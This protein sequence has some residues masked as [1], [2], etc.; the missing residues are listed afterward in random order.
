VFTNAQ[1][2][3]RDNSVRK[4]E[5]VARKI[6][7]SR[8]S[9][10]SRQAI[11]R[12]AHACLAQA[13]TLITR[14]LPSATGKIAWRWQALPAPRPLYNLD[15]LASNPTAFVIL[16]EG[17]KA[18]DAAAVL[19]PECVAT[20]TLNGAHSPH[21]SDFSPLQGRNVWIWP[22]HDEP[23]Y[24]YS[25]AVAARLKG[26]SAE[27]KLLTIPDEHPEGWDAANAAQEGWTE[28]QAYTLQ[29]ADPGEQA[30]AL[31]ETLG[32]TD[33]GAWFEESALAALTLLYEERRPDYERAISK[34]RESKVSLKDLREEVKKRARKWKNYDCGKQTHETH[35]DIA[36]TH[37]AQGFEAN[38]ATHPQTHL[39]HVKGGVILI[40]PGYLPEAVDEAE[41]LLIREET[42]FYQRGGQLVRTC[43]KRVETVRGIRRPEGAVP[44]AGQD[45]RSAREARFH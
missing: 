25:E 45:V 18:A 30:K 7:A 26:V 8:K 12:I 28:K 42:D 5:P 27:I 35:P 34:A 4:E 36:G 21:K 3:T 19:F 22:D 39:G 14:W 6:E 37:T 9:G 41:R 43:V 44:K 10:N 29:A 32:N 33:S 17:E 20:T 23:G 24:R 15:K 40:R 31:I 16:C 1:G 2:P 11:V 13:E 38:L